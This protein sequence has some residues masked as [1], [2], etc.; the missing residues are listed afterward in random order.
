MCKGP[1]LLCNC[2]MSRFLRPEDEMA[3]DVEQMPA[4]KETRA[5][6]SAH[7]IQFIQLHGSMSTSRRYTCMLQ[8]NTMPHTAL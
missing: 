4:R 6:K 2:A 5:C 3:S 1:F 8:A 7:T